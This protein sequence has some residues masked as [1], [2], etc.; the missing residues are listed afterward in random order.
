MKLKDIQKGK[1]KR[2]LKIQRVGITGVPYPIVVKDRVNGT[3][4][5]VGIITMSV[6]LP[7]HYKGTHMSR[8][9]EVLNEHSRQININKINIILEK[10]RKKFNAESAH[11]EVAF[12][13]F[14]TKNAP[15][16]RAEGLME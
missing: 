4:P 12:P 5:T 13:Y 9:I 10:L 15:E 11:L 1:P 8:F 3:Q 14:I 2:N 7:K 6:D 16:S